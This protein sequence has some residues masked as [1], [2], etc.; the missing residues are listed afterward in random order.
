MGR[1]TTTK[2]FAT[3]SRLVITGVMVSACGGMT[4]IAEEGNYIASHEQ[5]LTVATLEED[6]EALGGTAV[7]AYR[8]SVSSSGTVFEIASECISNPNK[9]ARGD[10]NEYLHLA[11][12]S[13]SASGLGMVSARFCVSDAAPQ[14]EADF[15]LRVGG[16]GRPIFGVTSDSGPVAWW[17]VNTDGTL[18]DGGDAPGQTVPGEWNRV[19]IQIDHD[20]NSLQIRV[21]NDKWVRR[22]LDFWTVGGADYAKCVIVA[23]PVDTSADIDDITLAAIQ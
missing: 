11:S 6:F 9:C 4:D 23:V 14:F 7:E 1:N 19:K 16:T 12:D 18:S 3:L 20:T 21:D 13:A 10:L 2:T 15:M 22:S 5:A 17:Y 8:G